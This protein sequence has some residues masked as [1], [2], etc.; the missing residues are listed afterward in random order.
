[1]NR[2]NHMK[3]KPGFFTPS[4]TDG[5][6]FRNLLLLWHAPLVVHNAKRRHQS[7]EWTILSHIDCF[8]QGEVFG[9]Q[10]MLDS[11]H[12]R[13]MGAYRWSPP[14]LQREAVKIFLAS[15]SSGIHA[16]WPNREKR[17]AWTIAERCGCPAVRL[18]SSFCT[19]CYHLITNSLCRHRW[20]RAS[21]LFTVTT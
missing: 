15:V 8:I 9:F 3:L 19:W 21:V 2:L 20:L 18:T 5:V 12:P 14:V 16:I 4:D 13:S 17:C 10:V 11:L 1:M 7:P 6:S